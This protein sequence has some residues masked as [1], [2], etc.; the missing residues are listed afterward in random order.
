MPINLFRILADKGK[1]PTVNQWKLLEKMMIDNHPGFCQ[2]LGAKKSLSENE[3]HICILLR[4]GFELNTIRQLM[5]M[6]A[7]NVSNIRKRM[8]EKIFGELMSPKA[9]DKRIREI[10]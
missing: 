10:M 3:Y 1:I 7:S 2:S 5:D 8:S 6:S 9:F 4:L